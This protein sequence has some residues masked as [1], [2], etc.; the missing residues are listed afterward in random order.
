MVHGVER[1]FRGQKPRSQIGRL[2][3]ELSREL[4]NKRQQP[5]PLHGA[6]EPQGVGR[7]ELGDVWTTN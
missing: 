6:A 2:A 4:L 5:A 3:R 1:L 7:T